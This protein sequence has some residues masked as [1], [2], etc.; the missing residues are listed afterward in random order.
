MLTS[1]QR[2]SAYLRF[3]WTPTTV[4]AT[5]LGFVLVPLALYYIADRHDVRDSLV[6]GIP[7]VANVLAGPMGLD[8]KTSRRVSRYALRMIVWCTLYATINLNK[9]YQ[10]FLHNSIATLQPNPIT[11]L[12]RACAGARCEKFSTAISKCS[13]S[14]SRNSLMTSRNKGTLGWSSGSDSISLSW[15]P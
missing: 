10:I 8:S 12:T 9:E 1:R 4:R 6:F 5:M 15:L 11:L 7:S 14:S 3:R 13:S 2:E